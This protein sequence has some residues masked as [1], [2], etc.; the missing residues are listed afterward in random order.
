MKKFFIKQKVMSLGERFTIKD[1][2]ENDRYFVKGSFMKV[3]KEFVVSDEQGKEIGTITKQPISLL[4]KFFVHVD[5]QE[6]TI[7]KQLSVLKAKYSIDGE[8]ISVK[9]DWLD[10]HFQILQAGNLVASIEEKWFTWGSAY[11]VDVHD[12]ALEHL[13][14]CFVIALDYVKESEQNTSTSTTNQ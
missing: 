11:E 7:Q 4:P 9:G 5:G 10:K 8:R 2:F 13:V 14:I 12:E 6:I 3:P 1:E